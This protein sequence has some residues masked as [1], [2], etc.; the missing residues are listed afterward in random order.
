MQAE[1]F[2]EIKAL[3]LLCISKSRTACQE[4]F[5]QKRWFIRGTVWR[6]KT[7]DLSFFRMPLPE[8][9][10]GLRDAQLDAASGIAGG[11]F[12]HASGFMGL[13]RTRDGACQMAIKALHMAGRYS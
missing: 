5:D 13:H 1:L 3:I 9:W 11:V 8:A 2:G 12:V 4:A 7:A 10:R 6:S